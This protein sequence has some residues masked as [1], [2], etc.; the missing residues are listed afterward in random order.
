VTS[1]DCEGIIE[2]AEMFEKKLLKVTF[3]FYKHGR[4]SEYVYCRN[5]QFGDHHQKPQIRRQ[6]ASTSLMLEE[7]LYRQKK[8]LPDTL[9]SIT[10]TVFGKNTPT[11]TD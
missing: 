10:T 9:R 7:P 8:S 6:S 5:P 2:T 11:H 1:Y 3:P 4:C